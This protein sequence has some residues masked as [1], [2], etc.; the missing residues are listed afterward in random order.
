M[1]HSEFAR[2]IEIPGNA[3]GGAIDG[4]PPTLM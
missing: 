2:A 4:I 3:L 1:E